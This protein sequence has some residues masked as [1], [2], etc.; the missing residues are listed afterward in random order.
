MDRFRSLDCRVAIQYSTVVLIEQVPPQQV[1][2]P[3][4]KTVIGASLAHAFTK[5]SWQR[6]QNNNLH[7][8]PCSAASAASLTRSIRRCLLTILIA[9]Y[10]DFCCF[11]VLVY[12]IQPCNTCPHSCIFLCRVLLSRNSLSTFGCCNVA[13]SRQSCAVA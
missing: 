12:T 4:C 10:R 11:V 2:L 13:W 1:N 7:L 9:V 6:I 8:P 3:L 5:R